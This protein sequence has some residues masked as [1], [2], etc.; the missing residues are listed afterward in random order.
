MEGGREGGRKGGRTSAVTYNSV[1]NRSHPGPAHLNDS[2]VSLSTQHHH[3]VLQQL[4][5]ALRAGE[6]GGAH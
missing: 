6:G 1:V 2:K 4:V 5:H 3:L